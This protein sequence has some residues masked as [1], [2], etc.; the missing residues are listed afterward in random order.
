MSTPSP[1]NY[2]TAVLPTETDTM[3]QCCQ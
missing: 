1:A 3:S 2:G